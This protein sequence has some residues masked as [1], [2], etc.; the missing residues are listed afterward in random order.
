[1]QLTAEI[2]VRR[3][4]DAVGAVSQ[5]DR[6]EVGFDDLLFCEIFFQNNRII[7]F[8]DLTGHR[9]FCGQIQVAGQ[10]L[11][12]R[13]RTA[14]IFV[15]KDTFRN[16]AQNAN[17]IESVV[18]EERFVFHRDKGVD[19]IFRDLIIGHVGTDDRRVYV[20]QQFALIIENFRCLLQIAVDVVRIDFRGGEDHESHISCA[21][22]DAGDQQNDNPADDPAPE[23]LFPSAVS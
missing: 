4:L 11:S 14:D 19:Q 22:Y 23:R 18:F 8:P 13:T 10:L 21:C 6:I 9:T 3:R 15:S 5:R 7:S 16:S 1:M 17:V 20:L 12:N 2:S